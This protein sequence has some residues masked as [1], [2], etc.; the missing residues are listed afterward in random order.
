MSTSTSQTDRRSGPFYG[1]I[2]VLGGFLLMATYYT[3]FINTES[4]FQRFVIAD[5]GLTVTEY[6]LGATISSLT[7]ILGSLVIGPL[8]DRISARIVG[9]VVSAIGALVLFTYSVMDSVWMLYACRFVAGFIIVSGTRLLASVLVANWFRKRQGL[10]L[11]LALSGSGLGGAIL[12][13]IITTLIENI[14]WRGAY[15]TMAVVCLV[16]TLPIA[17][18]F[19]RRRP[20]DIG[21]EPYG[22][23]DY[24]ELKKGREV[25][26][27][28]VDEE[29][30]AQTGWR[31]LRTNIPFWLLVLGFIVMGFINGA[32]ITNQVSNMTSI[33]LT[34]GEVI[35]GGH[36]AEWASA[37][38]S[39]Y[40]LTVVVGKVITGVLFD[41]FGLNVPVILSSIACMIASVGLCFPQTDWG[42]YLAAVTFGFGT[43]LGTV[44]PAIIISRAFGKLDLGLVNG[45]VVG[46]SLFG[47]AIGTALSGSVFDAFHTFQPIWIACFITSIIAAAMVC[48]SIA[49]IRAQRSKKEPL[50]AASID[51]QTAEDIAEEL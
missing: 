18:I 35:T 11:A 24:V 30:L 51:A 34:S 46:A 44:A 15:V 29:V 33:T 45:V 19:F 31:E 40:L 36:P 32:V 49:W 28:V 21:L 9:G 8:V 3:M 22:G 23:A 39:V 4:L 42:P 7:G 20:A 1:W 10:A 2:I 26:K 12:S 5:L 27:P 13:P 41:Y 48:G 25:K 38:L 37:V 43:C 6:N 17:V 47:Y 16:L 14:G 50:S